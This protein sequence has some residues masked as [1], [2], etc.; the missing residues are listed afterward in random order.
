MAHVTF[1]QNLQRHVACP[2]RDIPIQGGTVRDVLEGYFAEEPRIRGYVG[3]KL[4]RSDNGGET[5]QEVT[6]P[7]FPKQPEGQEDHL[8][9]GRPWPWKVEQI[10]SLEAGLASQPG[11]LWCGT[12]SGGLFRSRDRGE[13]WELVRSLWDLPER[14]Q[15]F[16]GG[17][18]LPG[19][20]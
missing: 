7:S 20:H 18:D 8:P 15:W 6:A 16:G 14:K 1:T 2:P 17:T 10:W 3:V 12:V 5:W 19:I 13:S 4:H 11:V 9:D